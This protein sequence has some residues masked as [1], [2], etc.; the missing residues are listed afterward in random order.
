[1]Y[2]RRE[3]SYDKW[4]PET[5]A[6]ST[7]RDVVDSALG[8]KGRNSVTPLRDFVGGKNGFSTLDKKNDRPNSILRSSI[9]RSDDD[10]DGSSG[11]KLSRENLSKHV[12][13]MATG[14]DGGSPNMDRNSDR[15][16]SPETGPIHRRESWGSAKNL[17]RISI[18]SLDL[19]RNSWDGSRRASLVSGFAE[20]HEDNLFKY[21]S[22]E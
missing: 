15:E 20:V 11:S 8:K 3:G 21:L 18:D 10:D 5:K 2:F 6:L 13:I 17:R 19:R 16:S 1:M 7:S 4:K 22:F 14:H 12:T 9:P